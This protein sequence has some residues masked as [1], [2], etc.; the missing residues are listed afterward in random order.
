MLTKLC[1]S[2][3]SLIII[4]RLLMLASIFVF[5]Q[6]L[7]VLLYYRLTWAPRWVAA[8]V[9]TVAPGVLFVFLGP[10]FLFAGIKPHDTCGMPAF[11]ALLML[12]AGTI[13]HLGVGLFVQLALV[14]RR[15]RRA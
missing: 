9:G 4:W 15:R 13:I 6:L 8:I 7:G 2:M 12:F 3:D 10:I 14:A 1:E 5:P 11:G